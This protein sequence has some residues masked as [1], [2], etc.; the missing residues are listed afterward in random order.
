MLMFMMQYYIDDELMNIVEQVERI[1]IVVKKINKWYKFLITD[2]TPLLVIQQIYLGKP[3]REKLANKR[4][5]I[6]I[7][8]TRSSFPTS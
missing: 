5:I 1:Y 3:L 7:D 8:Q 4:A 2:S 6:S